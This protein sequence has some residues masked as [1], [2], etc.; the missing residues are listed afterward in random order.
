MPIPIGNFIESGLWE[1]YQDSEKLKELRDEH[2]LPDACQTCFFVNQCRGGL[3]CLSAAVTGDP[4]NGD[5][6][7]W[8][9][10]RKQAAEVE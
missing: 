2:R 10:S 4:W 5:P 6:G 1:L 8:I 7:C 9:K 3:K